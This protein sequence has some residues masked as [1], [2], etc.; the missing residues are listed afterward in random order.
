[1]FKK[2]ITA[3][4]GIVMLSS[5]SIALTING[6]GATFPYPIYSKW[7]SEYKNS[8]GVEINYASIGSGGGIRQFTAG[9]VDFGASDAFMTDA[10]LAKVGTDVLHIPTV[11]GAVAVAYNVEDK[12]GKQIKGLRLDSNVLAQIFLGD[13]KKWS[14]PKLEAL[15]PGVSL[16]DENILVVHRSDASGTSSIFTGYLAKVNSKW[17]SQVGAGKAVSWPV[18]VGGKGNEGVT[19]A[20]KNNK[21]SIGYVELA[22]AEQ[23][24]LSTA[25]IKNKSGVY[26]EPSVDG[27]TAAADK[28]I[29]RIPSDFRGDILNMSGNRSYPIS[30]L[31]WLLVKKDMK[32]PEKAKALQGF[33][34]WAMDKGQQYAGDLYYAPLPQSLRAKVQ[35][36]IDSM[37]VD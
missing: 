18:G 2:I 29:S 32:N 20:V 19:G 37:V 11:L 22:Y 25:R 23:N 33:L 4:L 12:Y 36:S 8:A 15:N 34:T 10:E 28:G 35:K 27:V 13:I 26:V 30:G 31:T 6:A 14:D 24:D 17:A 9:V 16:P 7:M 21:D 1:M 5:M 3:V